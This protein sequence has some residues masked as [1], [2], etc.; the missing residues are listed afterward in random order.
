MRT[1]VYIFIGTV[2]AACGAAKVASTLSNDTLTVGQS[3]YPDLTMEQ[4]N[5]GKEI[6]ETQCN[7]CHGLKSFEGYDQASWG[8][9]VPNMVEK[10]NKKAGSSVISDAD[11]QDLLRYV[12]TMSES[13]NSGEEEGEVWF[14]SEKK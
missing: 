1:L 14:P 10:A 4:L 12:V 2:L 8:N 6:Y 11:Q 7:V 13:L 5:H 3:I 9:I